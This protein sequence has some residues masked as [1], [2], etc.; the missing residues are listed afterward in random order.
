[1]Q[2]TYAHVGKKTQKQNKSKKEKSRLQEK[3]FSHTQYEGQE[4]WLTT[5]ISAQPAKAA[6]G[7]LGQFGLYNKDPTSRKKKSLKTG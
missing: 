5:V 4:W 6:Q 1:M 2:W 7:A 3:M